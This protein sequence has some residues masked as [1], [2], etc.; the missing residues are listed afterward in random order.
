MRRKQFTETAVDRTQCG[1]CLIMYDISREPPCSCLVETMGASNVSRVVD[2]GR[3]TMKH[4]IE[5]N[6]RRRI[7]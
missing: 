3:G 5:F 2:E 7:N 1:S 6:K 4:K